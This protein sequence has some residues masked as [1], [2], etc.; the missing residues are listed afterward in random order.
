M[1]KL[2]MTVV[3]NVLHAWN[4]VRLLKPSNHA[5]KYYNDLYPRN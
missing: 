2:Q 5:E 4:T 1:L 3:Q